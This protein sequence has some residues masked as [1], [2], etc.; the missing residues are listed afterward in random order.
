MSTASPLTT[1]ASGQS[2]GPCSVVETTVVG[3][4]FI[5]VIH[6]SLTS[7]SSVLEASKC[8]NSRIGVGP[9]DHPLL[10]AVLG[11]A[12]VEELGT[13]LAPVAGPVAACAEPKPS[14]VEKTSKV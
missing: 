2:S 6:G 9:E 3:M 12:A 1:V 8:T 5:R 10:L 11:E 13:L 7:D 4:F 14:R